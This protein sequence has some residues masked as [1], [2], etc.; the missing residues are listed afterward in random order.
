MLAI[1]PWR[2][3]TVIPKKTLCAFGDEVVRI[4]IESQAE[5]TYG[6]HVRNVLP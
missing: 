3:R 1:A 5:C 2:L 6:L 4:D